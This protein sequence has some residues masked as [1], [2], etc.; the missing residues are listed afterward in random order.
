VKAIS[1]VAALVLAWYAYHR[2][3]AP[4]TYP[5]G[6]LIAGAGASGSAA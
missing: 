5:P 3:N 2:V 4:I 6:V 1:F